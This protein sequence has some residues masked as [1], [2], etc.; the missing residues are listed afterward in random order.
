MNVATVGQMPGWQRWLRRLP[1]RPRMPP[2]R[3]RQL[4][5]RFRFQPRLRPFPLPG[6]S[7]PCRQEPCHLALVCRQ[8]RP[9]LPVGRHSRFLSECHRHGREC[10][11]V[12]CRPAFVHPRPCRQ[13]S[14]RAPGFRLVRCLF[15]PAEHHVPR[16][17]PCPQVRCLRECHPVRVFRL[18]LVPVDRH[19]RCLPREYSRRMRHVREDPECPP[20]E[21]RPGR[22][23]PQGHRLDP[24]FH[25]FPAGSSLLGS[26]RQA[27]CLQA[28]RVHPVPRAGNL[29]HARRCHHR[30]QRAAVMPASMILMFHEFLNRSA[31]VLTPSRA[32]ARCGDETWLIPS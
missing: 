30:L 6:R 22:R 11:R 23:C 25:L 8:S 32:H 14:L 21:V 24:E 7:H 17:H 28:D 16:G 9:V 27:P 10:P 2:R 19:V 13:D 15:L 1:P 18:W 5:R 29:H 3:R 20:A 4:P 12:R 31:A 26:D